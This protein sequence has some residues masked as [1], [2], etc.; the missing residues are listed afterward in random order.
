MYEDQ[1]IHRFQ[2]KGCI[3]T[4]LTQYYMSMSTDLY[5]TQMHIRYFCTA[6]KEL[7]YKVYLSLVILFVLLCLEFN[8]FHRL[9]NDEPFLLYILMKVCIYRNLHSHNEVQVMLGLWGMQST[10]SLQLLPGPLWPGMVAPDRAL[11][12]G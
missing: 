2:N 11:S 4:T 8:E 9:F 10:P 7:Q 12:M 1:Y 6:W 5:Y 3:N